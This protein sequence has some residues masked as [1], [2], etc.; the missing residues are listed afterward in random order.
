MSQKNLSARIRAV[1][2]KLGECTA[3]QIRELLDPGDRAQLSKRLSHLCRDGHLTRTGE[4]RAYVYKPGRAPAPYGGTA[5]ERA[6]RR[7]RRRQVENERARAKYAKGRGGKVRA[8]AAQEPRPI[9]RPKPTSRQ[10]FV[11][12]P[13]VAPLFSA[14]KP[15]KPRLMTSQE[16][17]A[18]GGKVERLPFGASS[19]SILPHPFKA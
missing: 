19:S 11:I 15:A 14:P 10:Q 4:R 5:A 1:V 7:D 6:A 12:H 17:E 8:R 13:S 16:W 2:S 9:A 18:Q 3:S